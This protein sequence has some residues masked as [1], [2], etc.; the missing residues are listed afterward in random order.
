MG[1]NSLLV[2][3]LFVIISSSTF[4]QNNINISQI[5]S[6]IGE[7]IV[8]EDSLFSKNFN[9]SKGYLTYRFDKSGTF[10]AEKDRLKW[11]GKFKLVENNLILN[12]NDQQNISKGSRT[13][14]IKWLDSK[15][16]Y[17]ELEESPN[18]PKTYTYY[19]KKK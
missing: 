13:F 9:C 15:R 7:W 12:W 1:K 17:V 19:I 18:S 16:F 3:S 8:C 2:I 4:S 14:N 6:I 10:Y 11:S 5:E